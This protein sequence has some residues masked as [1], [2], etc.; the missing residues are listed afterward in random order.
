MIGASPTSSSRAR[1]GVLHIEG[2]SRAA[3]GHH[4]AGRITISIRRQR[5]LFVH[6]RV[7]KERPGTPGRV[8]HMERRQSISSRTFRG[9]DRCSP[10]Y[11]SDPPRLAPRGAILY[12]PGARARALSGNRRR[13]PRDLATWSQP[14]PL[15]EEPP[16]P[17]QTDGPPPFR[18]A[19]S[20]P[21]TQPEAPAIATP[22]SHLA[23]DG[24][25][26]D[27]TG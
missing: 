27:G 11:V 3:R 4:H 12:L 24:T 1:R 5:P 14:G 25:T 23:Q 6:V 22:C 21:R 8:G 2:L 15:K 20:A 13:V 9:P 7:G 16:P 10:T 19:D 18:S 17:P 26:P